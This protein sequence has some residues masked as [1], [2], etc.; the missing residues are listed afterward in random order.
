MAERDTYKYHLI[1]G[2]KIVHRSITYDLERREAVH[3]QEFPG[4]RIVQIGRKTTRQAG[5]K[6]EHK[7]GK[8]GAKRKL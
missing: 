1:L 5:L 2:H 7:G 4:S 8:K 3:Q 6:W